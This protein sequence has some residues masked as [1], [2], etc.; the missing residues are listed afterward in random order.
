MESTTCGVLTWTLHRALSFAADPGVGPVSPAC[1]APPGALTLQHLCSSSIKGKSYF[2]AHNYTLEN[3]Y[4]K[5]IESI[6][7]LLM[8]R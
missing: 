8:A 3:T 6:F 5:I 7:L 1:P 4:V 2:S